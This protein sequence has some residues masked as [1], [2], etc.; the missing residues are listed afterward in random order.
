[1][2][3]SMPSGMVRSITIRPLRMPTLLPFSSRNLMLSSFLCNLLCRQAIRA[4]SAVMLTDGL[5]PLLT[6]MMQLWLAPKLLTA[7]TSSSLMT[8]SV[9][10]TVLSLP[11]A[12]SIFPF[13]NA[14]HDVA[15]SEM[16]SAHTIVSFL[17]DIAV[18]MLF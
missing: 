6:L 7:S 8:F 1:M 9:S 4:S 11:V 16:V 18:L 3:K 10:S 13:P 2:Q 5:S 15:S 12:S 14:M 17:M